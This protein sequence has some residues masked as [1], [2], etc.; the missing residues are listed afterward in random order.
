M[1]QTGRTKK[2]EGS[3]PGI[4]DMEYNMQK[5]SPSK[6][7]HSSLDTEK[8]IMNERLIAF[9]QILFAK[10][11]YDRNGDIL[12]LIPA[13]ISDDLDKVLV[14]TSKVSE[15]ARLVSDN[16]K[17]LAD[18]ISK[19]RTYLSRATNFPFLSSTV[20]TYAI[21]AHYHSE[22]IDVDSDSFKKSFSI[23]SLL[24]PP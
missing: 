18:D 10:P 11:N 2:S 14:L 19:E 15:Q 17:V 8:S 4:I 24:A 5:S 22:P 9:L 6:P 3:V 21:Q 23:L 16:M 1:Q 7:S 20:I 13:V 12:S